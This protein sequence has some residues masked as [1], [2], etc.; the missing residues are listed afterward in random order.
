[1]SRIVT[2][3]LGRFRAVMDGD[4]KSWL[5]EC[6]NCKTWGALSRDQ[7]DGRVSVRCSAPKQYY[8]PLSV[9]ECDY[10]QTHEFAREL[11]ATIQAAILVGDKKEDIFKEDDDA[12]AIELLILDDDGKVVPWN[13][14]L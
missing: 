5:W 12:P 1:M 2:T 9:H 10:H 4:N 14:R 8:Y 6:P 13:G 11:V 7:W 3:K